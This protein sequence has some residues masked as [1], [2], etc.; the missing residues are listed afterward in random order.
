M[1]PRIL[2]GIVGAG[3]HET[4]QKA[5]GKQ[6][7]SDDPF[8]L[9]FRISVPLT[10]NQFGMQRA[11]FHIWHRDPREKGHP[12]PGSHG[13]TAGWAFA[14]L[15]A[16][17]IAYAEH[18]AGKDNDIDNLDGLYKSVQSKTDTLLTKIEYYYNYFYTF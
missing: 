8:I 15:N 10:K 12:D 4:Q 11:L 18:L 13:D 17:E 7:M 1:E 9:A 3:N 5:E 16:K 2:A 14:R 6:A